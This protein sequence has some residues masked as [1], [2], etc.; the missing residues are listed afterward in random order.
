[1]DAVL[2]AETGEV[3]PILESST[4]ITGFFPSIDTVG[5]ARIVPEGILFDV[6]PANR[7]RG[8]DETID[9]VVGHIPDARLSPALNPV[10]EDGYFLLACKF[11]TMFASV[12]ATN[13]V[14]VGV[15]CGSGIQ[16]SHAVLAAAV[17]GLRLSTLYAGSWSKWIVNLSREMKIGAWS[18]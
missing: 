14:E 2:S 13:K 9:P 5:V 1:M 7:L 18:H 11:R 6:R 3:T 16:A 15:Y 17:A 8:E 10:N 12:G 4:V